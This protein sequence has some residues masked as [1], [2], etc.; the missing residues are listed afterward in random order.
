MHCMNLDQGEGFQDVR[1]TWRSAVRMAQQRFATVQIVV[2]SDYDY[3]QLRQAV[4][5]EKSAMGY[6]GNGKDRS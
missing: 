1:P 2:G 4:S 5:H 6:S 3:S